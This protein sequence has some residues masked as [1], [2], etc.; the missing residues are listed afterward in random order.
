[1]RSSG[2]LSTYVVRAELVQLFVFFMLMICC[3]ACSADHLVAQIFKENVSQQASSSLV[4]VKGNSFTAR[5]P[6]FYVP[7]LFQNP[8]DRPLL[9]LK[10]GT[11]LDV[12]LDKRVEST[13]VPA[14]Y[15]LPSTFPRIEPHI[16]LEPGMKKQ[17]NVPLLFLQAQEEDIPGTYRFRFKITETDSTQRHSA[18]SI[19]YPTSPLK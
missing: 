14:N 1:M 4:E 6:V 17:L 10:Q 15:M 2:G 13:F 9:I 3:T 11:S 8:T 5:P 7:V 16:L 12:A 19:P 18:S